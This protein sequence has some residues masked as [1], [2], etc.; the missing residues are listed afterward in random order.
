V[1]IGKPGGLT[2][3]ECL[4]CGVPM[5]IWDP[6]PGQE[7]FNTYHILENGAG[8]MPNNA[9]TI[10]Y[11]VDQILSNPELKKRMSANALSLAHPDAARTIVDEM[12]SHDGET[13]VKAFKKIL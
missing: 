1:F 11:K 2:T 7:L 12:L 9:I 4:V 3:S 6:I 8:V 10:G 5:V 13:P